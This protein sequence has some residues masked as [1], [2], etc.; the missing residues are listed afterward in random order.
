MSNK[1]KSILQFRIQKNIQ[2]LLLNLFSKS[3]MSLGENKFF[4]SVNDVDIS[5]DLRNLKIFVDIQN[6]D[7]SRKKDIIKLLNKD[8]IFIIKDLLAKN[9]NLRYVPEPIF[10]LD[11]SNEKL[12]KMEKIIEKEKEKYKKN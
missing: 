4:I 1:S 7:E 10:I 11:N 9:I 2:H 3:E 5:P 8:N 6:I 12:F